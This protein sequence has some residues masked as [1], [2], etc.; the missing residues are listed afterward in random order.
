MR[1]DA[2]AVLRSSC[3]SACRYIP[4]PARGSRATENMRRSFRAWT[5]RRRCGG[6]GGRK[7]SGSPA[8]GGDPRA[9]VPLVIRKGNL[10]TQGDDLLGV[11]CRGVAPNADSALPTLGGFVT[12]EQHSTASSGSSVVLCLWWPPGGGHD[13]PAPLWS[14]TGKRDPPARRPG[15][16]RQADVS[17]CP[18]EPG[19]PYLW[20]GAAHMGWVMMLM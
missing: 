17:G 16:P 12:A 2:F 20:P 13:L 10:A 4:C 18:R 8:A 9:R 14:A 7:G 5:R 1:S 19:V 6:C 11:G 3:R 15:V